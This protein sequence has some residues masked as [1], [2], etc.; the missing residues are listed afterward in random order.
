MS[1]IKRAAPTTVAATPVF[2]TWRHESF[3]SE[4]KKRLLMI[5]R[6]ED[7]GDEKAK[8]IERELY[9]EFATELGPRVKSIVTG[10]APT[11][12][13][14][15]TYLLNCFSSSSRCIDVNESF[16]TTETGAIT[17][18]GVI[19]SNVEVMLRPVEDGLN[20]IST[21]E[22]KNVVE[23][24]EI[25]VKKPKN[26]ISMGYYANIGE[27]DKHFI[28]GYYA[29]GDIGVRL[30]DGRVEIV[31]RIKNVLKLSQGEFVV[32]H[33]IEDVLSRC[34]SI[35]KIFV[36]GNSKERQVVAIVILNDNIDLTA[37]LQD[38]I[39]EF[40][41][42]GASHNL[43]PY[44]I[45]AAVHIESNFDDFK[46]SL[47]YT[48]SGKIQRQKVNEYYIDVV[49]E[50]YES[51]NVSHGDVFA[52]I[53]DYIGCNNSVSSFTG[54]EVIRLVLPDSI[55]LVQ[56]S[57][58]LDDLLNMKVNFSLLMESTT[59]L[60]TLKDLY[61]CKGQSTH[62]NNPS[63]NRQDA[64]FWEKECILNVVG[65]KTDIN[66]NNNDAVC[67]K[68]ESTVLLTGATGFLGPFLL[69]YLLQ[70]YGNVICIVRALDDNCARERVLVSLRERSLDFNDDKCLEVWAGDL[71]Q[72]DFGLSG[73][74]VDVLLQSVGHIFHNGARVSAI[75]TYDNVKT[76]N[77]ESTK[78]VI[79]WAQ[80]IQNE[81]D[82]GQIKIHF[83]SSTSALSSPLL[84]PDTGA[85]DI[86]TSI[87]DVKSLSGYGQSKWVR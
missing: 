49:N 60:T 53:I 59:T 64:S 17:V 20:D 43:A 14:T 54:T 75:E 48:P 81:T 1:E 70:H 40:Q 12:S 62:A 16:G 2:W 82:C 19:S 73:Y 56:L 45:P 22:L 57:R 42:V 71:E 8:A 38:L 35:S 39:K 44:E 6:D 11:P 24:G 80:R 10:G 37:T 31:D 34:D 7:S 25:L 32:P 23:M 52:D 30:S 83:I 67:T 29:T 51:M 65:H 61:V 33:K 84:S 36:T 9:K 50:L 28:D 63:N 79:K 3:Q 66:T 77:V 85:E 72:Y 68:R 86:S 4:L 26:E 27:T 41:S 15:M 21:Y 13:T 58:R 69:Y 46:W 78:C 18:N 76:C 55:S 47:F 87:E 74:K 5:Q